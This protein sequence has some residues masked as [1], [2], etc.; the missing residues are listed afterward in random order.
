MSDANDDNNNRAGSPVRAPLTL[1]AEYDRDVARGLPITVPRN[2]YPDDNP[3]REP[4]VRWRGH[5]HLLF[6]NWL[7]YCV[8]Q[9]TPYDLKR[10]PQGATYAAF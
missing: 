8:Y 3:S 6:S 2:Y 5:A 7:N 4:L 9:L 10:I 1:K